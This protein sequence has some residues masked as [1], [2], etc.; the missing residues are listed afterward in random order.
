VLTFSSAWNAS[1][2]CLSH[3]LLCFK[4]VISACG[5]YWQ[6]S[7]NKELQDK[8]TLLEH[9]LASLS[10]DKASV[11]S[12]HNMSEEYVDELKKKVQS[13]VITNIL[14][15][16]K[17]WTGLLKITLFWLWSLFLFLVELGVLVQTSHMEI[18]LLL[19]YSVKNISK[20]LIPAGSSN[21]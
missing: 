14:Q 16:N 15:L 17:S 13:Q 11:N 2:F 12:E 5:D 21:F 20:K 4:A 6:C 19:F 8:V 10:G 7:E 9:R 1:T 18:G 3:G